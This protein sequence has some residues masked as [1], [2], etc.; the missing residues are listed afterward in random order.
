MSDFRQHWWTTSNGS[1]FLPS[2]TE[3][4]SSK[5][6][7]R[8]S[9]SSFSLTATASGSGSGSGSGSFSSA[10]PPAT[11]PSASATATRTGTGTGT[12]PLTTFTSTFP[13]TITGAT[14]TFTSLAESL[15]TT[16]A[17]ATSTT[18]APNSQAVSNAAPVC[19]G[20]GTDAS[21]NG[22]LASIIIP[23][24]IGLLIWLLFAILRPRF[25]QIYALREWFVEQDLR[26][27][28]LSSSL[29]AFLHPPVP[30]VPPLPSDVSSL[31]RSPADD[32]AL[33][34]ADE[35]L[36][37]RA[38]WIALLIA[39]GWALLGLAGALPLY[40]VALPCLADRPPSTT[41][42][43][44][45]STLED[46]SLLRL[47]RALDAGGANISTSNLLH[48]HTRAATDAGDPA[49][50]RIRIIVLTVLVLVLA[51]LPA[52]YKLLKELN[53]LI[54][55]RRR[56]LAL[57]CEG[58]QMGW[59]SAR[60][61]PGFAGWGEQRFK[62][63]VVKTGLSSG[64]KN[65]RRRARS[66]HQERG[67]QPDQEEKDAL[68]IDVT[69]VFSICDTH[70]LALLIDERDEILENLE[71]AE[72]RYIASFRLTTPDPSIAEY[73]PP[74]PAER[75]ANAS[76]PYISHPQPLRNTSTRVRLS[77]RLLLA[78]P[79]LHL[80]VTDA[81]RQK[82]RRKRSLN[83]AFAASSLAPTSFVAPSLY[84]KLNRVHGVSGG[85]FGAEPGTGAEDAET[86][87]G[88]TIR[89][90]VVGSRFQEVN[91]NSAAL[92]R[93][94]LGSH[95]R[96]DR[97]GEL[98]PA[99]GGG[100]VDAIDEQGYWIPDPQR[101]GPNYGLESPVEEEDGD[102][103]GD[104]GE[105]V[106]VF[107]E[108]P[109]KE[110]SFDNGPGPA[111]PSP[112]RRRAQRSMSG[113][114]T[115]TGTGTYT[116]GSSPQG[117]HEQ[118]P[119]SST[120]RDTF[121]F[122]RR[123]PD[124]ATD[125]GTGGA[126]A[127]GGGS[128]GAVEPPHMRLQPRQ[129]FVRPHDG[130]NF[131]HLGVV[132]GEITQWRSRLK[133]INGE[134]G[135]AQTTG[136]E[137]IAEGVR[138]KGWLL[139]G[140]GLR[141]IRGV[142]IIEGMAKEDVR[143][144]VLQ[145][146]RGALDRVVL[147]ALLGIAAVLLAAGLT[148]AAG[149]A[150]TTAP[151]VAHYLPFLS[152][153]LASGD[154]IVAG[155]ATVLAPAVAATLF[156]C[157][158]I[159]IVNWSSHIR[160][161]VSVSGG[162]LF[163]FKAMFYILAAIGAVWLITVGALIYTLRAFNTATGAGRSNT[164]ANGAIYMSILALSLIF[165]VAIVVPGL[166]LLQPVRLWHTIRA[167][168]RAVTPR[169]RF[170]AVYPRTYNPAFATG[171]CILA[172]I[173]ASTFSII[174]PLIAPAVVVLLLLTLVAHRFLVGY[175]YAR[176]HSQTG[177]LLQIWL[178]RR[179]GTLLSFQPIL[180]GL[181]F[182]SRK[183]W[184]E[185]GVCVGTGLFVIVF[186]EVYVSVRTR[187]PG[188][189]SLSP[190]ARDSLDSFAAH[191]ASTRRRTVDDETA[192][193]VSSARRPGH[194]PRGSMASVL[195]MMSVTLAV[196]PPRRPE[197]VSLPLKTETLDDLTATERAARTHPDAPPHLPP[198]F[199]DHAQEMASILYA[200]ELIAPPPIIWLPNDAAGVARSEAVDLQKYHDL[201]VTLDVRSKEDVQWRGRPRHSVGSARS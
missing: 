44:T 47:L 124:T 30:L 72:A 165:T 99:A 39:L 85:Q 105:W 142:E 17:L 36:S 109:R 50:L 126:G 55:Y 78:F 200:P 9:S 168:K 75:D 164:V 169:Q 104:G 91:R 106:D 21:A 64:M 10:L 166:L 179:F 19:I 32:A 83:P 115:G 14:T 111:S 175:V 86:P 100:G 160:G 154:T 199:V 127:S 178:L 140:R 155:L 167:E 87:L 62:D 129:P 84:Y 70:R 73:E 147:W 172:I 188:R 92:G 77:S 4:G 149:L 69:N 94:P 22:L 157:L 134:I 59:L 103:D 119:S 54:A 143:W 79:S 141:F 185:G 114:G 118:N 108:R 53:R 2:G 122:R 193:L 148:A 187:L 38:I 95:V 28:P 180:L 194:R 40:I 195:E 5:S 136:Y 74:S 93:L 163:V 170:R 18:A 48:L 125:G 201:Q 58:Q 145:N 41:F 121:P 132:Y 177:G 76:R 90:R 162:Q 43:G 198:L 33:F 56:W 190:I 159:A 176:T 98:G 12:G 82:P 128:L 156:I 24:V 130:I 144:D 113:T 96:V 101:F 191:A 184:I 139:V 45:L 112:F 27:K 135:D 37:Q 189:R 8:S 61:A 60:R 102:G 110:D 49:H 51:L 153:L 68:Q 97:T 42:G 15:V 123:K 138:I 197:Q 182:L 173:F 63:F 13:T 186:V 146:E 23:S 133:A 3:P 35:Q 20:A 161:S 107:K 120:K 6:T 181:I 116:A 25:R 31:G 34:P 46:L 67:D 80:L 7:D 11:T 192:S 29:L 89:A 152:P 151:D 16:D 117:E 137:D 57:R 174:F 81:W 26:P 65:E 1:V 52:L 131:D 71:I 158:A 171:A 150:L 183:F 196:M 88:Q 66:P